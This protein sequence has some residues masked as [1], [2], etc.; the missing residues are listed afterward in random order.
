MKWSAGECAISIQI[1][2][3]ASL[4]GIARQLVGLQNV[5][6]K[7]DKKNLGKRNNQDLMFDDCTSTTKRST[8]LPRCDVLF[9][10]DWKEY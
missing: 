4:I 6:A 3:L 5:P 2:P 7:I 9:F 10:L 1:L 8:E